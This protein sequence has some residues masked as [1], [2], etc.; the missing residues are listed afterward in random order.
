M[1]K[2]S[3]NG[4]EQIIPD[5]VRT[6][7]P[8]IKEMKDIVRLYIYKLTGQGVNIVLNETNMNMELLM[9]ERA[10]RVAAHYFSNNSL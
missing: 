1:V 10:Y 8:T 4:V 2:V 9:L 5:E 6:D 3:V 7:L